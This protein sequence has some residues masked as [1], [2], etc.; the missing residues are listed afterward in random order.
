MLASGKYFCECSRPCPSEA[1]LTWWTCR[2]CWY[3]LFA[4]RLVT[5]K[6]VETTTHRKLRVLH[7]IPS[8]GLGG[9]QRQLAEVVNNTPPDRYE[10]DVLLFAGTTDDFSRQWLTRRRR[11][12]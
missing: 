9:A 3:L 4:A 1:S 11:E 10:L 6:R 2:C 5:R 12:R 8:L 7:I